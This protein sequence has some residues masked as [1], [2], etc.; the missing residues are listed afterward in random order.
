MGSRIGLRRFRLPTHVR[1][2]PK[3]QVAWRLPRRRLLWPPGT[4]PCIRRR[5]IL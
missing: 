2:L 3:S 4:L 5:S 1:R